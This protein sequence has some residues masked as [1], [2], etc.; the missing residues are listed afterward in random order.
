MKALYFNADFVPM[1]TE[2]DTFEALLVGDDGKIAF[3]GDLDKARMLSD[4]CEEI[5]LQGNAVL[6]GFIDS[7]GHFG[8]ANM[9]LATA[10]LS[11]CESIDEI[12]E[13]LGAFRA[14]KNIGPEGIIVGM[15]YDHN[16]LA[17]QR[18]PDKFDLDKVSSSIPIALMHVSC[19]M[20]AVNTPMLDLCG[21]NESTPDP[22]GARYARV[23]DTL[24]P[25]GYV[26]ETAALLPVY[27]MALTKLDCSYDSLIDQ[28]QQFYASFGITTCQE[29][30]TDVPKCDAFARLGKEG[31]LYLD[32]VL[33]PMSSYPVAQ[34]LESHKGIDSS[35]YRGHVRIGGVKTVLDGSPQGRT[36]WMSEPYELVGDEGEGFCGRG[37]EEDEE[38]YA[39]AKMA[40]DTNHDWLAHANGDATA[41]QILRCYGR[42]YADSENPDK[43]KLR[44]VMIHCQTARRDQYE[45][46]GELNMIPSIFASHIWYW[47]DVHLKNFG[48][49]RGMRVS[50]VRDAL[51]QGLPFTFHTDCPVLPPNM[52]EAVWCAVNRVTKK[53]V[54]LDEEQKVGV[55]DALK[56]VTVNGAYQYH[57]EDRKGTLEAGKLADLVVLDRNPLKVETLD[58]RDIAVLQTIKEGETVY[59]KKD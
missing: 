29:G 37:F 25:S 7:H 54:Q 15:N 5:D 4:G 45:R 51:D 27:E 47:G 28:M 30:A 21:I 11:R 55:F 52:I 19:H 2:E 3:A 9:M 58:I 23:G 36:A 12:I 38:V 59:T 35:D 48:E 34:M 46:M 49:R 50:A 32:L 53:G 6:P 26:E 13:V 33:Y 17:E 31:R 8:L 20:M 10:D 43:D 57:E 16:N 24:E 44:P 42:A 39:F 56:A 40:I 22:E 41:E 14:E 18:H 1:T